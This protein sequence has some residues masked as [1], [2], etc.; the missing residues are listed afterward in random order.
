MNFW[1]V[2][3]SDAFLYLNQ[4]AVTA[5]SRIPLHRANICK[6]YSFNDLPA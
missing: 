5:G 3:M 4:V 1:F 2:K 6:S